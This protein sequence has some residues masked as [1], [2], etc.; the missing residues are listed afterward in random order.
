MYASVA[1]CIGR[2]FEEFDFEIEN[3]P[4]P[5]TCVALG[6][7]WYSG[8]FLSYWIDVL[9]LL[10]GL[11]ALVFLKTRI[12]FTVSKRRRSA[13]FL[14]GVGAI[15]LSVWTAENFGTSLGVWL[16]R[17]QTADAW[18]PVSL[19]VLNGW[20]LLVTIGFFLASAERSRAARVSPGPTRQ[21][22]L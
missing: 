20:A 1:S 18:R 21:Q 14:A 6:A 5:S 3:G 16:Y 19:Y 11:N 8:F 7:A 2:A 4:K 13:P 22:A 15:A 17:H 9:C 12:L 10:G